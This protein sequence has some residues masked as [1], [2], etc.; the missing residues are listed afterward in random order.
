[1]RQR[2]DRDGTAPDSP[3]TQAR[4]LAVLQGHW[5]EPTEEVDAEEL[6]LALELAEEE[7][8]WEAPTEPGLARPP[9]LG[10][11]VVTDEDG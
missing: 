10:L 3:G 5:E 7:N 6:L 9:P 2:G 4:G 8:D 1:M 11:R